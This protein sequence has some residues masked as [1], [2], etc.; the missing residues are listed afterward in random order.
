MVPMS[1]QQ[2]LAEHTFMV[3]L[4]AEH[5]A[6]SLGLTTHHVVRLALYHDLEEV[7]T[8][9]IPA[10]AKRKLEEAGVNFDLVFNQLGFRDPNLFDTDYVIV[11]CA[12]YI[13]DIVYLTRYADSPYAKMVLTRMR[14]NLDAYLTDSPTILV[15]A[16]KK[17]LQ[18]AHEMNLP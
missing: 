1:R 4:V 5:L 16:V 7:M 9:D 11:K 14:A 13:A 17:T 8:G 15:N 18:E 10:P 6:N 12:D 2:S 3:A